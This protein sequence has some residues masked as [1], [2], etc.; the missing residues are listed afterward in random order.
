MNKLPSADKQTILAGTYLED[1]K[2]SD[3]KDAY[4]GGS[5]SLSAVQS[6]VDP[7][8]QPSEQT[9]ICGL[10]QGLNSKVSLEEK[11]HIV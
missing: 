7:V 3:I 11:G 2:S 10:R 9:L 8:D 6:S 1:L 5:L 4:E